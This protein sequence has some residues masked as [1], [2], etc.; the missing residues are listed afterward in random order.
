[1]ISQKRTTLT[2]NLTLHKPTTAPVYLQCLNYIR[3]WSLNFASNW[4]G[5]LV[6]IRYDDL[7]IIVLSFV[8]LL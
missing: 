7:Y 1:M 5:K 3:V 4:E 8:S 6:K 2:L